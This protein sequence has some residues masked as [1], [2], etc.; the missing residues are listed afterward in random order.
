VDSL[1]LRGSTAFD[2]NLFCLLGVHAQ[3]FGECEQS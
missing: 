2:A 3:N 1:V